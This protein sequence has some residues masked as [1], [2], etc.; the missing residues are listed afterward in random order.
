MIVLIFQAGRFSE[1]FLL[2]SAAQLAELEYKCYRINIPNADAEDDEELLE[3]IFEELNVNRGRHPIEYS[4]S[5][6]DVVGLVRNR[7]YELFQVLPVGFRK[8]AEVGF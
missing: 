4:L 7:R 6:N 1:R 3:R 5:V 8:F 2:N